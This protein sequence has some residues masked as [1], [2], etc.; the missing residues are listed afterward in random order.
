MKKTWIVVLIIAVIAIGSWIIFGYKN[1]FLNNSKI[2]KVCISQIISNPSIDSIKNGIYSGFTK[3]GY[4]EGKNIVFDF[5]NAQGD[6]SVNQA[7]AQ[8]FANENCDLIIPI[9]TPSAQAV[10]NLIKKRP[11]VFSAV[12]DPISAGLLKSKEKPGGNITGTSDITLIKQQLELLKKIKPDVKKVGIV[13][14]PGEANAQYGL[15]QTK[16][17]GEAMGLEFVTA[18]ANNTNEILSAARSIADKVDAF[19][20]TTDNTVLTGQDALIKVS[21]EF[22]KPLISIDQSGVENGALATL[23]TNYEKVGERTAEIAIR[24]LKGENP[25]NIPV[26]GVTDADIFIN[27]TTAQKI[28]IAFPQDLISQAKQIYK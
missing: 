16:Q 9:S 1:S 22:K 14:N 11:I 8:K 18:P 7:I 28:G 23:S 10:A 26:L 5:Q 13:Y 6:M 25:G 21:I 17:Y 15:D 27:T 4:I 2:I 20:M 19:Y 24:V 3:A 12:T